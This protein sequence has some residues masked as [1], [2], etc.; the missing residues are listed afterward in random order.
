MLQQ[1]IPPKSRMEWRLIVNGVI[2]HHFQNYVLQMKV[3]DFQNRI[4]LQEMTVDKAVDEL[5]NL[6]I[7]YTIAVQI[8][9]KTIFK[10]W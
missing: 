8:D 10:T 6:C 9:I 2:K 4:R 1:S 3:N 5:Y 7:K